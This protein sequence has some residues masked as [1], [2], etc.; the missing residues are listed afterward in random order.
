MVISLQY[1]LISLSYTCRTFLHDSSE[2]NVEAWELVCLYLFVS[3]FLFLLMFLFTGCFVGI[4]STQGV[5]GK[6]LF[7]LLNGLS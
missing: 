2:R 7:L 6:T 5:F 4:S 1:Y 3:V